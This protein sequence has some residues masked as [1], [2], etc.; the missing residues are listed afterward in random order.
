MNRE[1]SFINDLKNTFIK[2]LLEINKELDSVVHLRN[3]YIDFLESKS[4]NTLD[5]NLIE[6]KF[7]NLLEN[8]RET[9]KGS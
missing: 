6:E 8:Y 3:S 4:T 7:T 5:L 9:L 1:D 2:D